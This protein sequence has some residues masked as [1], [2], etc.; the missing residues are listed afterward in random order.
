MINCGQCTA[1][2]AKVVGGQKHSLP[3]C[4]GST[5]RVEDGWLTQ[6]CHITASWDKGTECPAKAPTC[7]SAPLQVPCVFLSPYAMRRRRGHQEL[8]HQCLLRVGSPGECSQY[9]VLF[10]CFCKAVVACIQL[11]LTHLEILVGFVV[12]FLEV[13]ETFSS[14]FLCLSLGTVCEGEMF[15]PTLITVFL[16]FLEI[17]LPILSFM[18][19]LFQNPLL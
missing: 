4:A 8:S 16:V 3:G 2:I 7:S 9:C 13:I 5:G 19:E 6:S 12:G 11:I 15:L 1:H 10:S 17:A 14:I 18:E